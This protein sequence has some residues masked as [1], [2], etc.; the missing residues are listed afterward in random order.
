LSELAPGEWT[1]YIGPYVSDGLMA[2]IRVYDPV[3]GFIIHKVL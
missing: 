1:R 2:E 3:N